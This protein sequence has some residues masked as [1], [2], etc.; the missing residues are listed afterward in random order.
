MTD[1]LTTDELRLLEGCVH[2]KML[3]LQRQYEASA[4][5]LFSE[6]SQNDLRS[7]MD[8]LGRLKNKIRKLIHQQ[9]MKKS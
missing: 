3:Q 6:E 7:D 1:P 8:A 5:A 9:Q 2:D 4:E